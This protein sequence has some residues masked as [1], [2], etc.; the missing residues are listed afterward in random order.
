MSEGQ[1]SE[2][3]MMTP[4]QGADSTPGTGEGAPPA[5]LSQQVAQGMPSD[6]SEEPGERSGV[7]DDPE[8]LGGA[9]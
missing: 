8:D 7:Q 6:Y 5:D 1:I 3:S 2:T 4:Q 9:T